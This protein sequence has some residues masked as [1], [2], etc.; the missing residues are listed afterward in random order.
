MAICAMAKPHV[1]DAVFAVANQYL[2]PHGG[3][4][5]PADYGIENLVRDLRALRIL[6]GINEI[7]R[8]ILGRALLAERG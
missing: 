1:P 5:Y 6:K 8:P 3:Y 7:M 4:G 2:Q